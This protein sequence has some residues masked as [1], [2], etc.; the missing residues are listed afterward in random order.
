MKRVSTLPDQLKTCRTVQDSLSRRSLLVAGTTAAATVAFTPAAIA[1]NALNDSPRPRFMRI[2]IQYI[3]VLADQESREGDNAKEWGLWPKDPGPR[4]VRLSEYDRL[5]ANGGV[6]PSQ[7]KF[8]NSDWWLEENGLIMEA[9]EFPMRPGQYLVTG[10]R[11]KQAMLTIH[12]M[13]A[14]GKLHWELDNDANIYD[15]THL[16][17]RSARYTPAGGASS[18]TPA[19]AQQSDYP[20]NPGADMPPVEGCNK[21]DYAVLIIYAVAETSA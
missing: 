2:P 12:P 18:C 10:D 1:Q 16:R 8:D 11:E 6:A 15:V 13:G 21:Q 3:A 4:G 9:P 14:D 20:V 17:C 5:R 19:K 7:W